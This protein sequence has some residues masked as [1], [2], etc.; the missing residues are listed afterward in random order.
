[1]QELPEGAEFGLTEIGVF[2]RVQRPDDRVARRQQRRPRRCQLVVDRPPLRRA[3]RNQPA[4]RQPRDEIAAR[5]VGLEAQFGEL[6][7]GNSS[8]GC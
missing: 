5:L 6:V 2:L 7:G 3:P 8:S 4:R 1:M